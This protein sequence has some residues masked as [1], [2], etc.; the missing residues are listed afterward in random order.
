MP[1][2]TKVR[3]AEH[4]AG[5][6]GR[7]PGVGPESEKRHE[8]SDTRRLRHVPPGGVVEAV[9][10]VVAAPAPRATHSNPRSASQ[11]PTNDLNWS[12]PASPTC[13]AVIWPSLKTNRLGMEPSPYRAANLGF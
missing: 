10:V 7:F 2:S 4:A 8:D 5:R 12:L 1:V 13:S 3:F 6:L 9:P 11:R